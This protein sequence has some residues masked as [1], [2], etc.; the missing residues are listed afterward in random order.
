MIF[1]SIFQI[2]HA[3]FLILMV[4][5]PAFIFVQVNTKLEQMSE[6]SYTAIIAALL[7]PSLVIGFR[8]NSSGMRHKG[9]YKVSHRS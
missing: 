3:F 1:F 6:V 9:F 4:Q 2:F 7:Y 5:F 8:Y